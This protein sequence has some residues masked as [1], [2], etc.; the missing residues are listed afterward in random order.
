MNKCFDFNVSG[1]SFATW[2]R[3]VRLLEIKTLIV[4]PLLVCPAIMMVNLWKLCFLVFWMCDSENTRYWSKGLTIVI[5]PHSFPITVYLNIIHYNQGGTTIN[6]S[7]TTL[8]LRQIYR[9]SGILWFNGFIISI[10]EFN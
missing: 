1:P 3:L 8:L 7:L 6:L 9:C 4:T 10:L 2:F 5:I